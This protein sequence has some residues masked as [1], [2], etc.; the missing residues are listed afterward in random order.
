MAGLM[1]TEP[2]VPVNSQ[3]PIVAAPAS[4]TIASV[5]ASAA[6]A[7]TKFLNQEFI[8]RPPFFDPTFGPVLCRL[9]F[10]RRD[11]RY[12]FLPVVSLFGSNDEKKQARRCPAGKTGAA[13]LPNRRLS[14]VEGLHGTCGNRGARL[15]RY[16]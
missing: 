6:P 15:G 3:L 16:P 1:G 4:D 11:F 5:D 9:P 7:V 8:G 10:S 14:A 13:A 12:R 2:L